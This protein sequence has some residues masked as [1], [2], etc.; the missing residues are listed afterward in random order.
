MRTLWSLEDHEPYD[1][2]AYV[3]KPGI[4]QLIARTF[5]ERISG[6][7]KL[8][9]IVYQPRP[10]TF[11]AR[12]ARRKEHT[13]SSISPQSRKERGKE[14]KREKKRTILLAFDPPQFQANISLII[15]GHTKSTAH[16]SIARSQPPLHPR[17]RLERSVLSL[18][19]RIFSLF[20][21]YKLTKRAP[22]TANSAPHPS[23]PS[24]PSSP[25]NTP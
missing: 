5:L 10:H 3:T 8:H 7:R 12:R 13:S 22:Q 20:Q 15:T 24:A 4:Y 16:H 9:H 23:P 21:T 1:T 2:V 14:G 18:S 11:I 6:E 17:P 19:A 25:P